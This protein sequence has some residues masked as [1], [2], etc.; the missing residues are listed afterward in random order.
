LQ[1]YTADCDFSSFSTELIDFAASWSGC[2]ACPGTGTAT[3]VRNFEPFDSTEKNK[4]V[5]EVMKLSEIIEGLKPIHVKGSID[6]EITGLCHDSRHFQK[7]D[8]FIAIK[9]T[10]FDGHMFVSQAATNGAPAIVLED[11]RVV[12]ISYSGAVI[13]V[14]AARLALD[15]IA[16]NFYHKPSEKLFVVGVT[17]TNGKTTTTY[18]IEALLNAHHMPTAVI[19]T[20]DT[21]LG[22][23]K[24]QSSHTTPDALATQK[25]LSDWSHDGAKAVGMEVSSH[26]LSM[27]RVDSVE[28]DVGVFTNLTRD[29]LDFHKT[30]DEYIKAKSLFF[31]HLLKKSHKKNKR[32]IMNI[33]DPHCR[34]LA[35]QSVPLW[36]YGFENGDIRAQNLKLSFNSTEFLMVTPR[37]NIDVRLAMIGRHNV[38]NALAAFGVGLHL[39]FDLKSLSVAMSKLQGVKGRMEKV[40]SN[41][42]V[43]VFVD[44]AH[45]DDALK[46]VLSFL[47]NIRDAQATPIKIITVFGCGGDRDAGKRSVMMQVAQRFSDLTVVTSD[48]PRNEDPEKIIDDILKGANLELFDPSNSNSAKI[49]K[50]ADRKKA[51]EF[52]IKKAKPGDVVLIAGKGHENYQIIGSKKHYFDDVETAKEFL[53][54]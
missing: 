7:G 29:H 43:H 51:I 8:L 4:L 9:G 53:E 20:I 3:L 25:L 21:H 28:F 46:N 13:K 34:Q 27:S 17:G 52:A 6:T 54:K 23:K 44:Y 33:E 31:K 47:K 30:M 45:S 49:F 38:L 2:S 1:R 16:S 26:A 35:E 10:K 14:K 22:S 11:E 19:G 40:S 36:T 32:A 48:N 18:M 42:P 41:S 12:P 50:E 37:G 15:T 5:L 24:Y 39:N